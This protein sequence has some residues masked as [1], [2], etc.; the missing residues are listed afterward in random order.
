MEKKI[1]T[2]QNSIKKYINFLSCPLCGAEFDLCGASLKC[3]N[4]H[5]YDLSKKGY[6]NLFNGYTKI[7]KTYDKNLF[8]ARKTVSDTGLYTRLINK[9]GEI[10]T[11]YGKNPSVLDAGCG[12]GNL[13][14]EILKKTGASPLFAVDLSKDGI[15][16]A[17][18]N[19]CESGLIW[20]VANLNNLPFG[21]DKFDIILNIM[22]PA[23]YGEFKRTLKPGGILLKVMPDA[24]YLKELRSFIY[25]ENDKNE[26]SNAGVLDNLAEHITL[27]ELID[28][29]YTH[30]LSAG[31]IRALFEMTPLTANL[32]GREKIKR[33]LVLQNTDFK[34]T[35]AFKIA[36][37]K[38]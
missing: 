18:A 3:K 11:V 29:K 15:A 20:L 16:F 13:T 22:S 31:N 32:T 17:A 38:I 6:A 26:Y 2:A 5:T 12:C 25:K 19:F 4:S 9:T 37:C 35:L 23:N 14:H 28:I 27:K 10:L 8:S 7:V 33:E 36:V 1:N 24:D 30:T 21:E 34:A